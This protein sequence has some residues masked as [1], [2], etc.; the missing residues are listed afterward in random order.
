MQMADSKA[1]ITPD[2]RAAAPAPLETEDRIVAFLADEESRSAIRLGLQPFSDALKVQAGGLWDAIHYLRK[3]PL[4]GMLI[5]DIETIDDPQ[6]AL[7]DLAQVCPP[8]VR[9]VVV[10]LHNDIGFYRLLVNELG[11]TEYL[12][13]PLTRDSVQQLIAPHLSGVPA[14]SPSTRGGRI[15]TVSGVRGG[16]GGT[17]IAV[18]LA[19]ELSQVT[20]G[21]VVLL[22]LHLRNGTVAVMLGGRASSGLRI[23]LEDP[24]RAD[25]LFLER[26]AIEAGPRLRLIAA[27]EGF[28]AV[29]EITKAGV[30][31]VIDLLRSKFNYVVVDLPVPTPLAML[32]VLGEARH[33]VLVLTPDVAGVRDAKAYRHFVTTSTGTD[34]V[35]T[36]L[37]HSDIPGGLPLSLIQQGLGTKP[38]VIIPYLGRRMI[39]AFNLGI[40]AVKQVPALHKHLAPV[41]REVAGIR[42]TATPGLLARIFRR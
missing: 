42:R 14:A 9:V 16:A 32:P 30:T 20:K 22:D 21:H 41:V 1:L 8:D 23:A 2:V 29:T 3:T 25:S 18:N 33:V 15:I 35:I 10:G 6:A 12:P 38:E 5:V 17:T 26:T 11:V 19:W 7:D 28:E 37:N 24:S 39:S 40:P 13:K 31:R 34:R 4:D 27:E 36:I